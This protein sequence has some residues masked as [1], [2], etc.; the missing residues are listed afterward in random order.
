[1]TP[2]FMTNRLGLYMLLGVAPAVAMLSDSRSCPLRDIHERPE[3]VAF[4]AAATCHHLRQAA[5]EVLDLRMPSVVVAGT[6][7]TTDV[8][9][10]AMLATDAFCWIEYT[11]RASHNEDV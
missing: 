9:F 8:W 11:C 4:C 2:Q 5:C 7:S 10:A 3:E 1:M 6:M